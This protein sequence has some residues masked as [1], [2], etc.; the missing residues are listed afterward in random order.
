M[1]LAR[2]VRQAV[3]DRLKAAWPVAVLLVNMSGQTLGCDG[4]LTPWQ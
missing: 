2:R 4:D 3:A 1:A